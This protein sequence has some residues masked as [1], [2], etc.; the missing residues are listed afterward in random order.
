M[1]L[2]INFKEIAMKAAGHTA[3]AAVAGKLNNVAFIKKIANPAT[4]GIVKALIGYVGIPLIAKKMKLSG[5]KKGDLLESI[6]E[7]VGMIGIMQ[8][9]NSKFPSVFPTISGTDD[10]GGVYGYE[11][12]PIE[13]LGIPY[14]DDNVS[15]YENDPVSGVDVDAEV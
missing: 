6:G 1:K 7:G 12:N 15:G 13:G 14:E 3:G 2:G 8:A 10:E 11:Q 4:Q 5:G 9:A